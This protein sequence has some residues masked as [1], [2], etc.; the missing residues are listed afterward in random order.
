MSGKQKRQF[1]EAFLSAFS[2]YTEIERMLD[3][4]DIDLNTFSNPLRTLP[5]VVKDLRNYATK[6]N[7][8]SEIIQ[9]ALAEVPGNP[10]LKQLSQT[11]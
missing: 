5:E 3:Y 8:L 2:S 6:Q 1:D 9:G 11:I 4:I 10:Q 7:K